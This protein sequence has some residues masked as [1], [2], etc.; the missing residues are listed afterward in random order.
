VT[1]LRR[2]AKQPKESSIVDYMLQPDQWMRTIFLAKSAVSDA[3]N[4]RHRP[5]EDYGTDAVHNPAATMRP[6]SRNTPSRCFWGVSPR[7]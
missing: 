5:A 1:S 3:S 4:Q 6:T 7:E 2:N